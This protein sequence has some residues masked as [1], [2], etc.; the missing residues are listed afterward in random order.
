MQRWTPLN[1]RQLTVLRRV[2]TGDTLHTAADGTARLSARAL[3]DRGLVLLTKTGTRHCASITDAGRFYLEHGHHPEHP[4]RSTDTPE[5]PPSGPRS[6]VKATPAAPRTPH[7]TAA[8]T[9]RRRAAATGLIER[10]L[11]KTL[12]RLECADADT[13]AEWD[14]VVDFARR[15]R[16]VPPGMRLRKTRL[17][18]GDLIVRLLPGLQPGCS[19]RSRTHLPPVPIPERLQDPHPTVDE[20]HRDTDR[21]IMP[22]DLRHRCLLILHALTREALRRGHRVRACPVPQDQYREYYNWQRGEHYQGYRRRDGTVTIVADGVETPVTIMEA[23]PE[24]EDPVRRERL[25]LELPAYG[26][27]GY[28]YRWSDGKQTTVEASLAA[29]LEEIALRAQDARERQLQARREQAERRQAWEAAMRAARHRATHDHL[30]ATLL[31]QVKNWRTAQDLRAY[32]DA[33]EDVLDRADPPVTG[34][35]QWLTWAR[36]YTRTIDPLAPPPS[37]PEPPT[38]DSEALQPYLDGWSAQGPE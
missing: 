18:D 8:L 25:L 24:T 35:T 37:M 11:D 7:A 15:H 31:A 29:V 13:A 16:L 27:H 30:A 5:T 20:L 34:A 1:D 4:R 21:L 9:E 12:L 6:R 33:L 14:R 3:R 23:H 2:A 17:D 19:P 22:Q 28:Q 36:E 32:C 26:R 10:L 38:F